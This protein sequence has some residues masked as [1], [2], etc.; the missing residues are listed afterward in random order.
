[1]GGAGGGFPQ[2]P[3]SRAAG[4]SG[5]GA[6]APAPELEAFWGQVGKSGFCDHKH[7]V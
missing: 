1:M 4:T 5:R 2:A 3:M 7:L 6:A